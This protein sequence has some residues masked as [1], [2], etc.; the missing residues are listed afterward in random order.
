MNR[1]LGTLVLAGTV[2]GLSA[3]SLAA[4]PMIGTANAQAPAE[5]PTNRKPGM[6][7]FRGGFPL[8][9]IAL[10]HQQELNLSSDQVANLEKIRSNFQA[11]AMPLAQQLREYEKQI[12]AATEQSNLIQAQDLIKNSESLRSQLRYLRLEALANGKSVLS[13]QQ[14]DQ[15]KTLLTT[16]RQNF[17]QQHQRP[18][19]S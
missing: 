19:A 8:I 3:F 14:Q 9:S 2:A 4:M 16:M 12:R 7:H 18:Q 13:Q 17:R 5:Q 10:R 15:L 11:Q 1:K 6:H